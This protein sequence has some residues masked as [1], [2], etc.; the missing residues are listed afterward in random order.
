MHEE[1]LRSEPAEAAQ[2][3]EKRFAIVPDLRYVCPHRL[4]PDAQVA[5]KQT[6]KAPA[7]EISQATTETCAHEAA[8]PIAKPS[9]LLASR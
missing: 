3:V 2:G 4:T 9:I 7:G 1:R 5:R 6:A 8:F